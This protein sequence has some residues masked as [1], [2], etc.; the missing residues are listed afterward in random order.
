MQGIIAFILI[1]FVVVT[2]HEFGHF[3]VA[4]RSGIL[5]QEFAIGMGPKIF[6]KKIGETNF[7]IRLLPIG[8]YVKMPDNVFDFNNDV[9]PYD[10]KKGMHV[11]LKLDNNDKVEKIILDK[12]NDVDLLPI[13]LNDFELTEQLFIEG[14]VGETIERYSVRKDACVVFNGMEEQIAPIE[15]MFSSHSWGKKFWTLF[16]GPLMN[17]VLALAIFLGI[18]LYS[19]VP[20]NST[21]LGALATNYPAA[22]AGLKSGDVVAEVNGEKVSTWAEMTS[23]VIASNGSELTLKVVRDGQT[24]EV[25]VTPKEDTTIKKGKEVKT[26]K[27]GINPAYERDYLRAIK[28]GFSQTLYYGTM[29][30]TGIVNLFVSIFRGGF[31]LNQLGGPVAIYE[32]SS[33]A[34]QSGLIT[35]LRWTGILSVNLGLMNLIPIPVLDGGRIVF[36]IYEAIFKKPIN[37]KAQYYM[38]VAFGLLLMAL[39]LA[40]TWNDIQRLFGK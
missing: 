15:R 39:M 38:T 4:K 29:I 18:S 13:E 8:G 40:V 12:T 23:K 20:T 32:M 7:T 17:F 22:S 11:S 3:I 35:T 37:K 31:S 34:A 10:L 5:C 1:F 36:V 24:Q 21:R 14:F 25:K 27:L 19:G 33:A 30:F 9:S 2:I 16:A 28:N 26:Y 6:H